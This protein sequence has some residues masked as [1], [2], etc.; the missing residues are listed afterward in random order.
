MYRKKYAW[1]GERMGQ[2]SKSVSVRIRKLEWTP[3]ALVELQSPL[4]E[5]ITPFD[6]AC[7]CSSCFV[8]LCFFV[9]RREEERVNLVDQLSVNGEYISTFRTNSYIEMLKKAHKYRLG[10]KSLGRIRSSSSSS[11]LPLRVGLCDYLLEPRQQ[12]LIDLKESSDL[13]P[14]IVNFFEATFVACNICDLVLSSIDQSPLLS[15]SPSQFRDIHENHDYLRQKLTMKCRKVK[16]RAKFTRC[17]K[18]TLGLGLVVSYTAIVTALLMLVIHSML[19]IVA[20]P[21]V[22]ACSLGLVHKWKN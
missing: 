17:G 5:P 14:L 20:A 8:V 10:T 15:I 22:I 6:D 21:P 11:S 4:E 18:K 2:S 7:S 9:G 16:M 3:V 1:R 12:I 13:H 19:G